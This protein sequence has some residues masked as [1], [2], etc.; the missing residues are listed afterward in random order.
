MANSNMGLEDD[1]WDEEFNE[2]QVINDMVLVQR[3]IFEHI[4]EESKANSYGK[5]TINNNTE[6]PSLSIENNS[7]KSRSRNILIEMNKEKEIKKKKLYNESIQT[8]FYQEPIIDL[9]QNTDK[10]WNKFYG[11]LAFVSSVY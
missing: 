1:N 6:F 4:E 8:Y 7:K 9:P 11:E 3:F 2:L 10:N 5:M